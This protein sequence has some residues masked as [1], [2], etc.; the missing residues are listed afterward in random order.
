MKK[1]IIHNYNSYLMSACE[2]V[3]KMPSI[4]TLFKNTTNNFAKTAGNDIK[5]QLQI[6]IIDKFLF[7]YDYGNILRVLWILLIF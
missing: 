1:Y 5:E 3:K 7:F 6:K 4:H 2:L